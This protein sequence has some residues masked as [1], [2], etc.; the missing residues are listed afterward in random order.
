MPVSFIG[1]ARARNAAMWF[2]RVM[3]Q[4]P[5]P[6]DAF[7]KRDADPF[8][9]KHRHLM[10]TNLPSRCSESVVMR[11]VG[12]ESVLLDTKKG[13]YFGLNASGR[14]IWEMLENGYSDGETASRV[15]ERYEIPVSD[16]ITDCT[17]LIVSLKSAGLIR[18]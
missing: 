1:I 18:D 3:Y 2:W 7:T 8:L 12:A 6:M 16:A 11:T 10:S 13:T 14:Y 4:K 17:E 15:A 9:F 5:S